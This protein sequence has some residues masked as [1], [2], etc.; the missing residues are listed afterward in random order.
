MTSVAMR[1]LDDVPSASWG[2]VT[3]PGDLVQV[4]EP[5]AQ[6]CVW[7]RHEVPLRVEGLAGQDGLVG[8]HTLEVLK[9]GQSPTLA[10]LRGGQ[11]RSV[12]TA[13]L[14]MLGELL[15][16]LVGSPSFG[17]RVAH[18]SHAMCPGWHIDKVTMR[19]VCTY[20]GPGTEW[21]QDQTVARCALRDVTGKHISANVGDVVFLKG[22]GW[23]GNEHFGAIHRSPELSTGAGP[24]TVVTLDPLWLSD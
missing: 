21:L 6:L 1:A 12:L 11:A 22:S 8:K 3:D 18:V 4:L 10:T 24:R 17:L 9:S 7:Q 19:I 13:D 20:G 16:D 14:A 5:G 2:A 23:P 15:C